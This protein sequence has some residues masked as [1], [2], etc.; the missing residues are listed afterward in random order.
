MSAFLARRSTRLLL[1]VSCALGVATAGLAA[2]GGVPDRLQAVRAYEQVHGSAAR[3][4]APAALPAGFATTPRATCGPGSLPETGRQG[5]VPAVEYTNGRADK[6]YTCNTVARGHQGET[7]GYQVHRYVDPAGHTCAFYDSTLLFPRDVRRQVLG[8]TVLDMSNPRK[9]VQTATLVSPAMQTPHES[10]RLNERRGLLVAVAGNPVTQAGVVDVYD[11]A[12]DCRKPVLKSSLPVGFLGHEG[13]FSKDGMTYWASTTAR[14][15]I[16]AIGLENPSLP[17]ILWHSVDYQAHGMGVSDDGRRLYLSVTAGISITPVV[18]AADAGLQ[19]LDVSQV[20]RRAANPVVSEVS[21][22][23]WPEVSVPQNVFPVTID[24]HP[25]L[26]EFDEFD[27]NQT[28]YAPENAV[29]AV[30]VIDIQDERK[31][32]VISRIRLEVHETAARASDQRDD[33]QATFPVQGYAAHYCSVPRRTDPGILACSMILSGLRVF[34]IRDPHHP[35]EIAY[36]NKPRVADDTG[37]GVERGGFA[38]SAPAF[39]PARRA[40]WFSD[41]NSGFWNV[42][43]TNGTW[44]PRGRYP[45]EAS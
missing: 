33:P 26:V 9:P 7:G 8:T 40:I 43:L 20:Q 32:R 24:Q 17:S 37:A 4:Q 29:G 13:G 34:D 10:L 30:R 23:T 25:Y 41:G 31:P 22:L 6:G 2:A 39:D 5:R 35:R 19:I 28:M 21:R 1:A 12:T 18:Y 45:L 44:K 14:P 36:F 3:A 27:S 38:M 42:E 15:G 11:V 16:T